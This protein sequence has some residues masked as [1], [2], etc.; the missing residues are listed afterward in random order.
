MFSHDER[1]TPTHS[2]RSSEWLGWPKNIWKNKHYT[3]WNSIHL[4]DG[5]HFILEFKVLPDI[6]NQP[7]RQE[8]YYRLKLIPL[9]YANWYRLWNLK[10]WKDH[11]LYTTYY[12]EVCLPWLC[13]SCEICVFFGG[14]IFNFVPIWKG[15]YWFYA[16]Y[17]MYQYDIGL[18]WIEVKFWNVSGNSTLWMYMY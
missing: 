2:N 15:M 8:I 16:W 5:M 7:F 13:T 4:A 6:R 17:L 9:N 3:L 12:E 10:H 14:D 11:I 1:R 18:N